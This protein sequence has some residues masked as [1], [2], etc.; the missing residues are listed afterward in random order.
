MNLNETAA[1][2]LVSATLLDPKTPGEYPGKD[3]PRKPR[4]NFAH[5]VITEG[6]TKHSS[7]ERP[8]R[9]KFTPKR[10]RHEHLAQLKPDVEL[11]LC[12][13]GEEVTTRRP[14]RATMRWLKASGVRAIQHQRAGGK[15]PFCAKATLPEIEAWIRKDIS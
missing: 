8:H 7:G 10:S 4:Q 11:T 1:P 14:W 2:Y 13:D 3:L 5:S 15:D 12:V 9:I 6:Y